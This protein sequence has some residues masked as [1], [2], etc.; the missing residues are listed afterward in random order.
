MART[1]RKTVGIISV[2]SDP[3]AG[4]VASAVERRG[5]RALRI[6]TDLVP[7]RRSLSWENGSIR[8]EDFR[9]DELRAFYLKAVHLGV[10]LSA[11]EDVN[12]RAFP[13][14]QERYVA[15]RE[16]NAFVGS[17]LRNLATGDRTFA[18]PPAIVEQH[19]LKLHQ[20]ELLR[21]SGVAVP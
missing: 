20:L 13:S 9:I 18:K 2:S 1:R 3:H 17:V 10:P 12:D 7:E 21:T 15:E 19:F 16:R 4:Y 8:F 11:P 5:G 6:D 14:W